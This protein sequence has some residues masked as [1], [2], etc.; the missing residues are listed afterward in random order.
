MWPCRPAASLRK[1]SV[2]FFTFSSSEATSSS[3][4]N[5]LAG[6]QS[7]KG[8]LDMAPR[9]LQGQQRC[10]QREHA[11]RGRRFTPGFPATQ[12]SGGGPVPAGD[13]GLRV[14]VGTER[15]GREWRARSW[16]TQ[17]TPV[18]HSTRGL[19]E[20][21]RLPGG[22][23]SLAGWSGTHRRARA[24]GRCC[25]QGAPPCAETSTPPRCWSGW[26]HTAAP[27]GAGGSVR[28][29]DQP[30]GLSGPPAAPRGS[31]RH[32]PHSRCRFQ[33]R[34]TQPAL[35]LPPMTPPPLGKAV[36]QG[37]PGGKRG[38]RGNVLGLHEAGR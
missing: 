7:F 19:P 9:P 10:R 20:D 12:V 18:P 15:E 21:P 36:A 29:L 16:Q 6:R 31:H 11:P 26:T 17:V 33:P 24:A 37:T 3:L 28:G 5:H 38:G 27:G 13:S 32:P 1:G 23:V 35:Y 14:G 4:G 34:Y 2:T 25:S 22:C 30:L 8:P